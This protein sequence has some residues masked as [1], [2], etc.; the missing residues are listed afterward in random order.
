MSEHEAQANV[1]KADKKAA[2][3]GWFGGNKFEEA[4]ELYNK[5]ANTFKLGKRCKLTLVPLH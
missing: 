2:S 1:A 4:S 3:L 5:A